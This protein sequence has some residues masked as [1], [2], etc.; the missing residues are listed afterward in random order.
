MAKLTKRNRK[1]IEK[2]DILN[3][4]EGIYLDEK[5]YGEIHPLTMRDDD[6]GNREYVFEGS[7]HNGE[8]ALITGR[9]LTINIP[10]PGYD[11]GFTFEGDAQR[12]FKVENAMTVYNPAERR[13]FCYINQGSKLTFVGD[14]KQEYEITFH[15]YDNIHGEN[16]FRW[17]VI[18]AEAI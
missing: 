10:T 16:N 6:Y 11:H 18:K 3:L 4:P 13:S 14:P 12:I 5:G 8:L 2:L 15:I 17:V 7:L 9:K 1:P